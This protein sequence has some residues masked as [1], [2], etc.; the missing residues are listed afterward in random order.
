MKSH[1]YADTRGKTYRILILPAFSVGE[2][3]KNKE[4]GRAFAV[5]HFGKERR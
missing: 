5:V 2:K 4:D 3:R 1:A